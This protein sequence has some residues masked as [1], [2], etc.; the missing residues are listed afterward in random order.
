MQTQL[1]DPGIARAQPSFHRA[2]AQ[3]RI[4]AD[5]EAQVRR[6]TEEQMLV[7]QALVEK[8]LACERAEAALRDSENRLHDLLAHQL[9]MREDERK[10]LSQ[11][12]HDHLAQNLL[13]LRLDIATLYQQTGRHPRLHHWVGAALDNVDVTLRSVKQLIAGLRPIGMDLGLQATFEIE[14]RKFTHVSGIACDLAVHAPEALPELDEERML[15][16]CRVLQECLNNVYRHSLAS[17]VQV[18]LNPANGAL[19]L[20]IADNGIG[21]DP[22]MAR[23]SRSYGL[24]ALQERVAMLGGSLAVASARSQGTTVSLSLPCATGSLGAPPIG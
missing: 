10:R 16:V 8:I 24:F 21:F 13:A 2:P 9:A 14:L 19:G 11:A 17:R 12:I 6:L 15:T 1:F 5:L 18:T 3:D 4:E 22:G 20:V 7:N 23:K